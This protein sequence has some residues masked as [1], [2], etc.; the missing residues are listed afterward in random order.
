M[1]SVKRSLACTGVVAGNMMVGSGIALLPANLASIGGIAIWGCNFI[2]GAMSPVYALC[3]AGNQN[4]QQALSLM[5]GKYPA[6][7]FPD[8]RSAITQ[9]DW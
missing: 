3:E 6:F 1:S 4:P 8:R 5:L 7:G 9:T 2:I